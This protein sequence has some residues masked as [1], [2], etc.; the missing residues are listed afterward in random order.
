MIVFAG[1]TIGETE[2]L[3]VLDGATVRPPARKGDIYKAIADGPLVIGLIDGFFEGVPSVWHKEILWA[4]DQGVAVF[5]ASSMGA[6]R[7][8]EL[9]PFGMI[10]VGWIF[11]AYRDGD[12]QD[13]DE[14]ALRHGPRELNYVALS[15]PMVNIRVTLDKAVAAGVLDRDGA[16]GLCALAKGLYF[17][18][19]TWD[20]LSELALENGV[21]EVIIDDLKAWLPEGRVDQ[22]RLDAINMLERMATFD[23][24][25]NP[26]TKKFE[27]QH[28]VMW[29]DLKTA[30][31]DNEINLTEL[32]VIDHVRHDKDVYAGVRERAA[33][34]LPNKGEAKVSRSV[35][36]GA[37]TQ[38]RAQNRLYTG[39]AFD[40]WLADNGTDVGAFS[41]KL[42]ADLALS[43]VI[44]E[45]P[46]AFYAALLDVLKEE[47]LFERH[48][49]TA[50]SNAAAIRR[51]GYHLPTPL[52][53][54]MHPTALLIWYF[55]A[56][57]QEAVPDDMDE[58]LYRNDFADRT[59]FEQM[60]ARQY[61]LWQ[62]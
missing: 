52:D 7:A 25:S 55:E 61:V 59:A 18:D 49:E 51:S 10:G 13:D 23:P 41:K 16:V 22:K 39:A 2:V 40:A 30:C 33:Q 12:I 58:F 46:L 50:R 6:L 38:F 19:R 47:G 26:K 20:T 24:V 35:I 27:F 4:L 56:F 57:R 28:T 3:S 1:P 15:E 48:A 32:L 44:L 53:I 14:V 8:T 54:G 43:H 11:E 31:G 60:M 37:L 9:A 42:E 17:P 45:E 21:S 62:Q 29:E 34:R 36:D 5:G